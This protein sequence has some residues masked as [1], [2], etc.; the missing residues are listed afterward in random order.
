MIATWRGVRLD[1]LDRELAIQAFQYLQKPDRA[2]VPL[3]TIDTIIR[4]MKIIGLEP[5][6]YIS[7]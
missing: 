7:R 6:D 2:D 3:A 1:C 5:A 4:R